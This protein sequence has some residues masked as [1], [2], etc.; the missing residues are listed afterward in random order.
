MCH[1]VFSGNLFILRNGKQPRAFVPLFAA[2]I[3]DP[4][5]TNLKSGDNQMRS[6]ETQGRIGARKGI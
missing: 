1:G 6:V 5:L 4:E 2:D 3:F